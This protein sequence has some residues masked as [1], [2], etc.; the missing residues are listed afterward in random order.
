MKKLISCLLFIAL[1]SSCATQTF[2]V[3]PKVKREVPSST[4]HFSKWSNFFISGV[5]QNDFKSANNLCKESGGVA[6]V[7]STVSTGQVIVSV[8]T[9]GIYTPRTMNIYCNEE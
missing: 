4:P 9:L 2:S 7:E 8:A 1:A 5:G 6:F 3:N